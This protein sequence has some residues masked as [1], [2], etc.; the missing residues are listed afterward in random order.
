MKQNSCPITRDIKKL[1]FFLLL[2][3]L[4]QAA[5]AQTKGVIMDKETHK[6]IPFACISAKNGSSVQGGMSDENGRF[7]INFE[8]KTLVFSHVYYQKLELEKKDLEGIVYLSPKD[9]ILPE[10]V[11]TNEQ[12]Q[13]IKR[14]LM[15]V[16]KNKAAN[17]QNAEE[18][19]EYEYETSTLSDSSGYSFQ[20]KGDVRIP[21]MSKNDLAHI[22]AKDNTIRYKDNKAKANFW[23][24]REIVYDDFIKN[25]SKDFLSSYRIVQ[26]TSFK[27]EDANLVQLQFSSKKYKDEDGF[28][29]VD[30]TRKVILE[31]EHRMGKDFNLKTKTPTMLRLL[32][33][34]FFSLKYHHWN[35]QIHARYI[36]HSNYYIL[37]SAQFKSYM[38]RSSTFKK[39]TYTYFGSNEA[40]LR[41]KKKDKTQEKDWTLLP[42]H[43]YM[44]KF[45]TKQMQKED[46]ALENVPAKHESY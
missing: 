24:F 42:K 10:I 9:I 30:T 33:E 32:S 40:E 5:S 41:L 31:L 26:N 18:Q 2:A 28:L 29:V 3:L 14:I 17:Y 39:K 38:K 20:S 21:S 45:Y 8:F 16:I 1:C 46:Q 15:E 12:P 4:V 36:Q 11:I 7:E 25:L 23:E 44:A 22:R 13:W 34:S 35:M 43:W 37:S 6:G 19:F 27:T